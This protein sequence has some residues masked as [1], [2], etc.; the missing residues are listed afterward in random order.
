MWSN[1]V[2][3]A[4]GI[5]AEHQ[6]GFDW[7]G[8][9]VELAAGVQ[10]RFDHIHNGLFHTRDQQRPST[11][12]QDEIRQIGGGPYLEARVR[13]TPWLRTVTGLRADLFDARVDSDLAANSG[14]RRDVLP[15]PKLSVELGPWRRTEV[16]LNYGYGFHSNDAR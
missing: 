15:S 12:P 6:W 16:Y 5:Q 9:D 14:T 4:S 10:T 11:T 2:C 7:Q 3:F 8:R 1:R 13:W